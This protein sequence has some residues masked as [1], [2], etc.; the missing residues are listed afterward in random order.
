M[1]DRDSGLRKLPVASGYSASRIL[2]ELADEDQFDYD[3]HEDDGNVDHVNGYDVE[4]NC[5]DHVVKDVDGTRDVIDDDN[6]DDEDGEDVI[7]FYDVGAV[8]DPVEDDEGWSLV[9]AGR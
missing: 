9:V 4:D 1:S 2:D 6:V 5:E 7:N 8:W 3:D